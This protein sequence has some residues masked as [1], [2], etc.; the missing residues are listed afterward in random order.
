VIELHDLHKRYREGGRDRVVLDGFSATVERGERLALVGRSGSGKSTLLNLISGMDAPDAGSVRIDG[1]EI[2]ALSERERTLYRRRHIGFVFQFFNLIPTLNVAE[3]LF[4]PLQ[5]NGLLDD[6]RRADALTLLERVGLADRMRS[7]PDQLSGGE[8]QRIAIAR[9]LVH[10]P[11][12]LLADEPT[13]T[14]DADTGEEVLGLL[15]SLTGNGAMTVI[16]VT[17]SMEV[18]RRMDR[19]LNLTPYHA[20]AGE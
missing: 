3:N 19:V 10:R 20:A 6:G 14:L 12:L 2:T 13:G 9:A 15:D 11:S 18:A 16:T 8:Q 4:L 7:F 5:L 17:H 1:H